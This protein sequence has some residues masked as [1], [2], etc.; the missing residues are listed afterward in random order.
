[1]FFQSKLSRTERVRQGRILVASYHF[2]H[3]SRDGLVISNLVGISP[4]T[5][6]KISQ[7]EE[8][9]FALRFWKR[10]KYTGKT[11]IEGEAYRHEVAQK[12]M[13]LRIKSDFKR[14]FKK[15]KQLFSKY[16]E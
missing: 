15:W 12:C 6:H 10:K 1:M 14:A 3:T 5:L 11:E 13:K 2:L 7:R 16:S 8:W 4:Y 9:Y